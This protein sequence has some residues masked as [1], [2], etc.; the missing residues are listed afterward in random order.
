M[1]NDEF[2]RE[3]LS[4]PACPDDFEE[5]YR[6]FCQYQKM[7][8]DMLRDVAGICEKNGIIYT[9]SSG[10]V[11]GAVRDGGQIPWDYDVDLCVPFFEKDRLYEALEKDLDER[12][13]FYAPEKDRDYRPVFVRVVP[14]GYMHQAVHVDV[15][16]MIGLPD[17]PEE[18][19]AYCQEVRELA[20]ARMYVAEKLSDYPYSLRAKGEALL[21]KGRYLLKY[22]EDARGSH[23]TLYGR[24]DP[25]TVTYVSSL[26]VH[27]G[28]KISP[29]SRY[30]EPEHIA[31]AFGD[32]AVPKDHLKYLEEKYGDWQKYMPI[33]KRIGEVE[34]ICKRFKWYEERQIKGRK[35]NSHA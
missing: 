17:D 12:F 16:F 10:S 28:K 13:C 34:K 6:Y 11:L 18:R 19:K 3:A 26:S 15:F 2:L 4:S 9:L 1:T 7:A 31:T 20:C 21:K 30:L 25:R 14:K 35:G 5:S 22:G 23:D 27:C 32:L 8:T 29:A 24:Y 33:E